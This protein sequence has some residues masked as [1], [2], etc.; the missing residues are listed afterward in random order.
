MTNLADTSVPAWA[1]SSGASAPADAAGTS[2]L[3]VGI[4]REAGARLA[5]WEAALAASH[6]VAAVRRLQYDDAGAARS[7]L[8]A[9][10]ADARVGVR[11]R[12]AGPVGAC[13]ALR[14]AAAMVGLEEEELFLAPTGPGP[15]DLFCAHC[16]VA[17]AVVAAIGDVAAC[18]GCARNLVIYHHVSRRNG[19]FLGYKIDAEEN[20][21]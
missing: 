19:Q 6:P 14:G 20:P 5:T 17:T 10:L 21:E 13:L 16:G 12:L 2:F 3:L 8:V 9:A 11:V 4:G 15:I 1:V 18:G 7:A